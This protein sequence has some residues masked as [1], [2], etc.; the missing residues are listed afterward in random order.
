MDRTHE[1]DLPLASLAVGLFACVLLTSANVVAAGKSRGMALV[2]APSRVVVDG[3]LKEWAGGWR[4]LEHDKPMRGARPAK[5]D[6]RARTLVAM[7]DKYLYVAADVRD[8]KL[9]GGK[10]FVELLLGIPGGK[11]YPIELFPGVAG[12]RRAQA[13]SRGRRISGARIVE[14]PNAGGYTLEARIPW[15]S[16]PR[17]KQVRLGY[18]AA[19]FVH[20]A[21]RSRV[22]TVIG[23]A[24]TRS[25]RS[26]PPLSTELELSLGSGLLRRMNLTLPPRYNLIAD[27]VGDKRHERVLI[28]GRF[29]IVL[30]PGYRSGNQYFYRDLGADADRGQLLRFELRDYSGDNK[31]DLLIRKRIGNSSGRVEVL[32]ILSYHSGGDTPASLFAHE[33]GLELSAGHIKNEVSIR[34]SGRRTKITIGAGRDQGLDPRRFRRQSS[35]GAT[36]V[37]LP[38][39]TIASQSY[40]LRAGKFVV[41]DEKTKTPRKPTPVATSKPQPHTSTPPHT[42]SHPA[43]KPPRNPNKPVDIRAVY[44]LYK[45]KHRVTT[46]ASFDLKANLAGDS[47]KERIVVHGT[48]LVVFGPGFVKGRG[49]RAASMPFAQGRD[50]KQVTAKDITRDGKAE[51][52]VRGMLRSP[53]PSDTGSGEMERTVVLIFKA[54]NGQL[55]QVFSAEIGRKI[56]GKRIEAKLSFVRDG[57]YTIRLTPGK[58]TGYTE[59]T[60]PWSQKAEPNNGFEPL[61]L[62]WGGIKQVRLRYEV[63]RFVR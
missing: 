22:E 40:T 32:E 24:N 31:P 18:R 13:K 23:S 12:S 28:Y 58:A 1:L 5:A 7:D 17:S 42:T 54:Q 33:V 20:D 63:D 61:L 29:L 43:V 27:V 2:T 16:V 56:D 55:K 15:S 26:L 53:L 46:A 57:R 8:D 50:V 49:Y 59:Y 62:P 10:D 45:R 51:I 34:G 9:V 44:A 3:L 48:D 4:T 38:W 30:G 19:V 21:D 41:S 36:A 39:G 25:Y 35:T 6:L 52:I 14:A 37:L 11:V 60:Y 47:R